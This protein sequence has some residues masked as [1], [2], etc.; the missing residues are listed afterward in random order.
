MRIVFFMI[1]IFLQQSAKTWRRA[2]NKATLQVLVH[3]TKIY[4]RMPQIQRQVESGRCSEWLGD[5]MFEVKPDNNLLP[6]A[7]FGKVEPDFF[8]VFG[9]AGHIEVA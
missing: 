9:S 3:G 6:I 7:Q 1:L 2:I 5:F 8:S 4:I